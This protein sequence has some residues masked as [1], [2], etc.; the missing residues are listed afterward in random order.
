MLQQTGR[1][2]LASGLAT[3]AA[4]ATIFF[5]LSVPTGGFRAAE[6]ANSSQFGRHKMCV[7]IIIMVGGWM[8]AGGRPM[9]ATAQMLRGRQTTTGRAEAPSTEC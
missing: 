3:L 6:C 2:R 8:G 1:R 7:I 9:V 5:C 4:N